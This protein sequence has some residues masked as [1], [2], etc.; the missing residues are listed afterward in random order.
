[1][2][3]ITN[4]RITHFCSS[5]LEQDK[6]EEKIGFVDVG[7]GGPLKE[8]WS[9]LPAETINK[10]DF[11]PTAGDGTLP[12]CVSN[13]SGK[14]SFYVAFNER[15]SSLHQPC[16]DFIARYAFDDMLTKKT[17]PV[18]CTSLDEHFSGRYE[19][20]DAIDINVE[21]HDFQVL[22]GAS[23]LLGAG[24]IKILK[25]EF[26]LVQAYEG[27][28]YFSD[29]DALLRKKNFRLAGIEIGYVRSLKCRDVFFQGEPI[30][31]KALYAPTIAA[32]KQK[33]TL[34]NGNNKASAKREM[35]EAISLYMAAKLPS[36]AY[37]VI[38][39]AL[40]IGLISQPESVKLGIRVAECFR[41]AKFE[42]RLSRFKRLWISLWNVVKR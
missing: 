21:G 12:L 28:G 5:L 17:I 29:I 22:Q 30:W 13:K 6:A 25:V 39:V 15:D 16:T 20:I 34:T 27:Q 4:Q 10:F 2:L 35:A 18:E 8:P 31:G 3:N 1:M 32:F 33:L 23:Q 9:L 26:E 14:A 11:E 24:T 19:S 38:D 42:A 41:W 37:D 40:T 36:Y 7:S